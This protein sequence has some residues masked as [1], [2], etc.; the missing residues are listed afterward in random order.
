VVSEC[1]SQ[2]KD[3][4]VIRF[5]T[6]G[7]SFYIKASLEA[8]FAALSFPVNFQ[9]ARKN[10]VDLFADLIGLR[11]VGVRQFDNERSFAIQL[12]E[13][14][15]LLFKM[16][17]NR[18][19]ILVLKNDIVIG[20][21]KNSIAADR[22][23]VPDTL[24][25]SINW[26]AEAF[27][28]HR[29]NPAALYVTFGKL[30]WQFLGERS[31]ATKT[32]EEQWQLILSVREM[33]EAPT[34]Y[35]TLINNV[36][37]LSLL[38]TGDIVLETQ[39]P[40]RAANEFYA[41]FTQNQALHQERAA[42]L[43]SLRNRLAASQAYYDKNFARL[44]EL[45]QDNNYKSWADLI[46]ANLHAIPA[47]AQHVTLNNFY[48]NNQPIGIK[49]RK[50]LSPQKNAEVYYRKAK[51]QHI[52]TKRLQE[53]LQSKEREIHMLREQITAVTDAE[54]LKQIRSMA[55]AFGTSGPKNK[56]EALLPYH[57]F[58][59]HGFRIWVGRNAQTNDILTFRHGY[60]EDLWLHAKDVAGSHVLIK[61]QA[62]K[63][64]PKDV[65]ERA[66]ELAAYNSKRKTETLCPVIVTPR[67]FIRK[68]KGDPAGAVVIEREDV[69][70]VEPKLQV[71]L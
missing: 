51:N 27:L 29:Q 63:K 66:A 58:E 3:E 55:G 53:L 38:R 41:R 65:I 20:L 13:G 62:G 33:L 9:R 5:E 2:S 6:T 12:S 14:T 69:I 47:G 37:V 71:G 22:A 1:F 68:R 64:F 24:N 43:S 36:P 52:E 67:K 49:L 15:S 61:Y 35:I 48:N 40:L 10:S 18:A 42:A 45:E 34:F 7:D 4:L 17:G 56:A 23:L 57:E 31:F 28:Q 46:M 60:K 39:D 54:N 30:V 11:V 44:T 8:S 19:N 25:R 50:D 26:S 70:M 16:H 21:F 59:F 32:A